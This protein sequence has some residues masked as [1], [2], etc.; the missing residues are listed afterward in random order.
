MRYRAGVRYK[1]D[2]IVGQEL[3]LDLVVADSLTIDDQ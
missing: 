1:R 2:E 3:G